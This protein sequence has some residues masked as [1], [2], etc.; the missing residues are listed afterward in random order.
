MDFADLFFYAI[1]VRMTAGMI[2]KGTEENKA[3]EDGSE[4]EYDDCLTLTE[5][6]FTLNAR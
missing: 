5:G 1:G 3:N 6:C 4:A 2:Q